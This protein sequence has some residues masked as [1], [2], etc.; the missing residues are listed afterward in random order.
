M[1]QLPY[2]QNEGACR[3]TVPMEMGNQLTKTLGTGG[4]DQTPTS[5]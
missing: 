3:T 1:T 4:L 5:M 2:L